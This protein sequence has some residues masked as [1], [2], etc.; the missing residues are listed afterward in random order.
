MFLETKRTFKES[1]C[2]LLEGNIF[3]EVLIQLKRDELLIQ[4]KEYPKNASIASTLLSNKVIILLTIY[5]FVWHL[6][7]M[8]KY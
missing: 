4:K 3:T 7:T 5:S 8:L 6:L 1:R 2:R